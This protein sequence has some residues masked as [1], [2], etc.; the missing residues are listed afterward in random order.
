[1]ISGQSAVGSGQK[2]VQ[3]PKSKVETTRRFKVQSNVSNFCRWADFGHWTLDFGQTAA[4]RPPLQCFTK[5][6]SLSRLPEAAGAAG[7]VPGA[8]RMVLI[9][10]SAERIPEAR[11]LNSSAL[12]ALCNASSIEISPD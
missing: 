7:A 8:E 11:I 1:M 2:K 5:I 6:F 12:L 10:C 9:A 3:S 4:P